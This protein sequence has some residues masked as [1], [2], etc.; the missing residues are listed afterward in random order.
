MLHHPPCCSLSVTCSSWHLLNIVGVTTGCI[1]TGTYII[2]SSNLS[3]GFSVTN[4]K[5]GLASSFNVVNYGIGSLNLE[6]DTFL[7]ADSHYMSS[8]STRMVDD[9]DSLSNNVDSY[10]TSIPSEDVLLF[11]RV[12][13]R[14]K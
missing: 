1:P 2:H 8:S 10:N 9:S 11:L 3:E 12:Q 14:S 5:I 13:R 6:N 4:A 7:A